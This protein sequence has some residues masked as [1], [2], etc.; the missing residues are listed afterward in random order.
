MSPPAS[1]KIQPSTVCGSRLKKL[2]EKNAF[3]TAS[4]VVHEID[5]LWISRIV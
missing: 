4:A 3:R 1:R 2:A 5:G